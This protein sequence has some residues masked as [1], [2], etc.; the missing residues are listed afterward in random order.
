M[1]PVILTPCHIPMVYTGFAKSLSSTL[2]TRRAD[3][4]VC[5]EL[6]S[7]IVRHRSKLVCSALNKFPSAEWFMWIDSD[8][9]WS[10]DDWDKLWILPPEFKVVSGVYLKKKLPPD[11]VLNQ[12]GDAGE[13]YAGNPD[14]ITASAVPFGFLRCHRSVLEMAVEQ[15]EKVQGGWTV[16]FP[17]AIRNGQYLTEDYMFSHFLRDAGIKCWLHRGVRLIHTGF[18]NYAA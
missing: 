3:S 8:I 9:R 2:L 10:M 4:W 1:K 11:P 5:S 17:E 13:E 12:D 14:V 6:D 7:S 15:G 18:Y 16:A